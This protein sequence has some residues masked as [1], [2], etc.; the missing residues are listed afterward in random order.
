VPRAIS[1]RLRTTVVQAAVADHGGPR[2]R[3]HP[4]KLLNQHDDSVLSL[5]AKNLLRLRTI[6]DQS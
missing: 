1:V 4:G 6:T 2:A 5:A 3:P